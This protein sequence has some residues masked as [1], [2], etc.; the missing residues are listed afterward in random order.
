MIWTRADSERLLWTTMDVFNIQRSAGEFSYFLPPSGYFWFKW[1]LSLIQPTQSID[2][3]GHALLCFSRT[4]GSCLLPQLSWRKQAE[5]EQCGIKNENDDWC[6]EIIALPLCW[7]Q[8]N[9]DDYR[10]LVMLQLSKMCRPRKVWVH[11]KAEFLGAT[12]NKLDFFPSCIRGYLTPELPPFSSYP[13]F[14]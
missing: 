1:G 11:W 9:S 4:S 6:N 14:V 8:F 12:I 2:F 3:L 7:K 10:P 5:A 13:S